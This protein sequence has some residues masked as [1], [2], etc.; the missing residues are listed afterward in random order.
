MLAVEEKQNPSTTDD[1]SLKEYVIVSQNHFSVTKPICSSVFK[2]LLCL[3]LEKLSRIWLFFFGFLCCFNIF[4]YFCSR[5]E[6]ITMIQAL[7]IQATTNNALYNKGVAYCVSAFESLNTERKIIE[8]KIANNLVVPN[9]C[10]L[11]L[12]LQQSRRKLHIFFFL[13]TRARSVL[14]TL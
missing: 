12:S 11:S 14:Q 1:M 13:R 2:A 9:N 6:K 7:N 10:I 8:K 3:F 5:T 4:Y